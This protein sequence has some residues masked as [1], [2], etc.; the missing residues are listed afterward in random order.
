M[1]NIELRAQREGGKLAV[2][3][4]ND[5]TPIQPQVMAHLNALNECD[6]APFPEGESD[7]GHGYAIFNVITRIRLLFGDG[8]GLW[9]EREDSGGTIAR[10]LLPICES[11]EAFENCKKS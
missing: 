10:F 3:V 2:T 8:Y 7:S 5:G 1:L 11:R 4:R 6:P 9:Y